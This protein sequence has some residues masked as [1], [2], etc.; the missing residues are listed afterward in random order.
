[1]KKRIFTQDKPNIYIPEID[2][3]K[4]SELFSLVTNMDSYEIKEFSI[5]HKIPI[6]ITDEE[7]N[8]LIHKILIDGNNKNESTKLNI[9][10]F[11]VNEGISLDAPNKNNI[12]ALHLSCEK[13]CFD[14]TKYLLLNGANPNFKDNNG[15]NSA[16]YLLSGKISLCKKKRQIDDFIHENKKTNDEIRRNIIE[17]KKFLGEE[18]NK[19]DIGNS[20]KVIKKTIKESYFMDDIN[21]EILLDLQNSIKNNIPSGNINEDYVNNTLIKQGIDIILPL[22]EK[23]HSRILQKWNNFGDL[24]QINIHDKAIRGSFTNFDSTNLAT[25]QNSDI[26]NDILKNM[27]NKKE[28]LINE[29]LKTGIYE[30]SDDFKNEF[31]KIMRI[32]TTQTLQNESTS[33]SVETAMN[34]D[35][36]NTGTNR[37]KHKLAIDNADNILNYNNLTFIGGSRNI[38]ISPLHK[39]E[40]DSLIIKIKK[41]QARESSKSPTKTL[42]IRHLPNNIKKYLAFILQTFIYTYLGVG[43]GAGGTIAGLLSII[44]SD[45]GGILTWISTSIGGIIAPNLINFFNRA[46]GGAIEIINILLLLGNIRNYIWKDIERNARKNIIE[47]FTSYDASHIIDFALEDFLES[48]TNDNS[49]YN[50]GLLNYIKK[51]IFQED[52]TAEDLD[53]IRNEEPNE[54]NKYISQ[55]LDYLVKLRNTSN[56]VSWL[57]TFITAYACRK[58]ESNLENIDDSQPHTDIETEDERNERIVSINERTIKL[59]TALSIV[60]TN[61]IEKNFKLAYLQSMKNDLIEYI[62][63]NNGFFPTTTVPGTENEVQNMN[64]GSIFASWIY[65]L[66]SEDPT[67]RL[68]D[69]I[70]GKSNISGLS[71]GIN[72]NINNIDSLLKGSIDENNFKLISLIKITYNCMKNIKLEENDEIKW[73]PSYKEKIKDTEKVID[74]ILTYYKENMKQKCLKQ[75]LVDTISCIRL[76]NLLKKEDN[77]ILISQLATIYPYTT[78][79]TK[80]VGKFDKNVTPLAALLVYNFGRDLFAGGYNQYLYRVKGLDGEEYYEQR[81]RSGFVENLGRIWDQVGDNITRYDKTKSTA[82]VDQLLQTTERYFKIINDQNDNLDKHQTDID[83]D[84]YNIIYANKNA[85]L[86]NIWANSLKFTNLMTTFHSDVSKWRKSKVDNEKLQDITNKLKNINEY[87]KKFKIKINK[88]HYNLVVRVM[89]DAINRMREQIDWIRQRLRRVGIFAGGAAGDDMEGDILDRY[90]E[91]L[92]QKNII[93]EYM[94][95]LKKIYNKQNDKNLHK[96]INKIIK[97]TTKDILDEVDDKVPSYL[98]AMNIDKKSFKDLEKSQKAQMEISKLLKNFDEHKIQFDS[99]YLDE[100]KRNDSINDFKSLLA[101]MEAIKDNVLTNFKDSSNIYTSQIKKEIMYNIKQMRKHI[102]ESTDLIKNIDSKKSE[103]DELSKNIKSFKLEF[104]KKMDLLKRNIYHHIENKLDNFKKELETLIKTNYLKKDSEYLE[105]QLNDLSS[106]YIVNSQKIILTEKQM[107]QIVLDKSIIEGMKN[108][109]KYKDIEKL[110]NIEEYKTDY[111]Y[112]NILEVIKNTYTTE[113]NKDDKLT[114]II[115]YDS[116][117]YID[118]VNL[119]D[120]SIITSYRM[121]GYY[122]IE[123]DKLKNTLNNLDPNI[124]NSLFIG[125]IEV[126]HKKLSTKTLSNMDEIAAKKIK[127][128]SDTFETD[129]IKEKLETMELERENKIKQK[130]RK[131]ETQVREKQAKKKR[132]ELAQIEKGRIIAEKTRGPDENDKKDIN[133]QKYIY[134]KIKKELNDHIGNN[135]FN[136]AIQKQTDLLN[137]DYLYKIVE[138]KTIKKEFVKYYKQLERI[139]KSK[140]KTTTTDIEKKPLEKSFSEYNKLHDEKIKILDEYHKLIILYKRQNL[141][142]LEI[143]DNTKNGEDTRRKILI[144]VKYGHNRVRIK[145]MLQLLDDERVQIEKMEKD[146]KLNHILVDGKEIHQ[147]DIN[148]YKFTKNSLENTFIKT[149]FNKVYFDNNFKEFIEILKIPEKIHRSILEDFILINFNRRFVKCEDDEEY[150]NTGKCKDADDYKYLGYKFNDAEKLKIYY[151]EDGVKEVI[152]DFYKNGVFKSK[153]WYYLYY[154][155]PEFNKLKDK[156]KNL[157]KQSLEIIYKDF[158]E[159]EEEN[160]INKI[161]V[162]NPD[163]WLKKYITSTNSKY[164]TIE[165][166]NK[167]LTKKYNTKHSNFFEDVVQE[168]IKEDDKSSFFQSGGYFNVDDTSSLF[169][170]DH[171]LAN[172]ILNFSTLSL[173]STVYN[174]IQKKPSFIKDDLNYNYKK[175]VENKSIESRLLG[176]LYLG[177]CAM[178]LNNTE[179]NNLIEQNKN[180]LEYHWTYF[181][182]RIMTNTELDNNEIN[183]I[184][185]YNPDMKYTFYSPPSIFSVGQLLVNNFVEI[186]LLKE[187]ILSSFRKNLID[188]PIKIKSIKNV[189]SYYYPILKSLKIHEDYLIN[190]YNE[191]ESNEIE[192]GTSIGE[193]NKILLLPFKNVFTNTKYQMNFN[194]IMNKISDMNGYIYL[195]SYFSSEKKVNIDNFFYSQIPE[196][197]NSG[198]EIYSEGDTFEKIYQGE[199]NHIDNSGYNDIINRIETD[200]FFISTED[201]QSKF[202][203]DK[204]KSLPPSLKNILGKYYEYSLINILKKLPIND[205]INNFEST[206]NKIFDSI[207]INK[208]KDYFNLQKEHHIFKITQDIIQDYLRGYIS[209]II[210]EQINKM[211]SS[212]ENDKISKFYEEI[213]KDTKEQAISLNLSSDNTEQN[214]HLDNTYINIDNLLEN[215][216]IVKDKINF[217]YYNIVTI[218]K[219]KKKKILYSNDYTNTHLLKR[220]TCIEVDNNSIDELLKYQT[221]VYSMDNDSNPSIHNLIKNYSYE[222][223]EYLSGKGIDFRF[224]NSKDTTPLDYMLNEYKN[225]IEKYIISGDNIKSASERFTEPQYKEIEEIIY[226]N[227]NFG[228]NIIRNLDNSF[229]IVDYLINQYYTSN[230]LKFNENYEYVNFDKII[231]LLELNNNKI[232]NTSINYDYISIFN[233]KVKSNKTDSV[234]VK[235]IKNLFNNKLNKKRN[236]LDKLIKEKGGLENMKKSN[237]DISSKAGQIAFIDNRIKRIDTKSSTLNKEIKLLETNLARLQKDIKY[238]STKDIEPNPNETKIIKQYNNLINKNQGLER[239]VYLDGWNVFF[240]NINNDNETIILNKILKKE[241]DLF[242]NN[243]SHINIINTIHT[244]EPLYKNWA[245]ISES[246]F[247]KD[248]YT[249]ENKVLGYFKD[250]L[251]H[252]TKNVICLNIEFMIRKILLK[253]FQNTKPTWNIK[254]CITNIDFILNHELKPKF[255]NEYKSYKD[256]LYNFISKE[257]VHSSIDEI[258]KNKN[259]KQNY[260]RRII[261]N[262]LDEYFDMMIKVSFFIEND[263]GLLKSF[264]AVSIYFHTITNKIINNWMVVMENKLRFV[265]NQHRIIKTILNLVGNMDST[266]KLPN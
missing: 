51:H 204:D 121:P 15:M 73:I 106:Y 71:N 16:H 46:K 150:K 248:K 221:D 249:D 167:E 25:L 129:K 22:K 66:L 229:L 109:G 63:C 172:T 27:M 208:S 62:I 217:N 237:K 242:E 37:I 264:R 36:W 74:G 127:I 44:G 258:Y 98:E 142:L 114:K 256:I 14:I 226:S 41:W 211:I 205:I 116:K 84:N 34:K 199:Y 176:L 187:P 102:N 40:V 245:D 110:N 184:N 43:L 28:N 230:L 103:Y 8:T 60:N 178:D 111:I 26:L 200:K 118:Y 88:T 231:K 144:V 132:D 91:I 9:I 80:C 67:K 76:R 70:I 135:N 158:I 10:K 55:K 243:N 193:Y 183:E 171:D 32:Y 52:I 216:K 7:G 168:D 146:N 197:E 147:S 6:Y 119:Y 35:F 174:L 49:D 69:N 38:K 72:N 31:K 170:I 201:I 47:Q 247:E 89:N 154:K 86:Q 255:K 244:I 105:T 93:E 195:Y 104:V 222:T 241:L 133:Y 189:I 56:P 13:Q 140:L 68:L 78:K 152:F 125:C 228:N 234:I 141:E 155:G 166:N 131:E 227:E 203:R 163:S 39:T 159:R 266:Q 235:D 82:E 265:I 173:P 138:P 85:D 11:L 148:N 251:I 143:K 259:D 120:K 149:A 137:L 194:S 257:L 182:H 219:D 162:N 210:N 254:K 190:M 169:G 1:M 95:E 79:V 134:N 160:L 65:C 87:I 45:F 236:K 117:Y 209:G 12:S 188:Y 61:D 57:H 263:S 77:K 96:K 75:D 177:N 233:S 180:E 218:P 161:E 214:I 5:K 165:S 164:I 20:I 4:I 24:E 100:S 157:D 29:T 83:N 33:L 108:Q 112:N 185:W 21:K 128:E 53:D 153:G 54:Y 224:I 99:L 50:D 196:N 215:Q 145:K 261:K 220:L 246:Y 81:M 232:I 192:T 64:I 250:V 3:E 58:S 175:Y 225:H 253:Y 139:Y 17:L 48:F 59:V 260:N 240:D 2:K 123:W 223:I 23:I 124:I 202:V 90:K 107:S 115:D 207:I 213:K 181:N 179:S 198:F 136:D 130:K 122:H 156:I 186:N 262:I 92:K 238:L 191:L 97:N 19:S 30:R 18:I 212:E 94:E 151:E 206:Y 126:I 42:L 239:A 252:L 101:N 113:N